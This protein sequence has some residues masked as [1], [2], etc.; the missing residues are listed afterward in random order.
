M[1]LSLS[2]GHHFLRKNCYDTLLSSGERKV[3][4]TSNATQIRHGTKVLVVED[5][6]TSRKK[7][8]T[9]TITGVMK[10]NEIKKDSMARATQ[11]KKDIR[12][13]KDI[14]RMANIKGSE[15]KNVPFTASSLEESYEEI[16]EL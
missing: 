3:F 1:K 4:A 9:K 2:N 14:Q 7:D 8:K 16:E 13:K 10:T 15:V 6:D 11:R 12:R 5:K